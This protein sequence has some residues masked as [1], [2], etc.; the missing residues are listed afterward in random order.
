M[1]VEI[2]GKLLWWIAGVIVVGIVGYAWLFYNMFFR[3]MRK[4]DK[5]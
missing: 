2:T 1:D 5:G 3:E 4:E